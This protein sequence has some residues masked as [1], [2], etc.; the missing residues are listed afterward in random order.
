MARDDRDPGLADSKRKVAALTAP[1]NVV[2]VGASD[3]PGSWAA[4]VFEN[5]VRY[6]FP[7]PVYLVNPRRSE[8][9]GRPCYPDFRALPEPPD[10]LCVVVPAPFVS[11]ALK[12]AAAAG[13]RSATVLSAGFGE[14]GDLAGRALRRELEATIAA[15]GLAVSGPNC[16]GNI[17]G[18]SRLVTISD[19][20][21]IELRPGPVALVGQSGG[22][23]IFTN[24]VL[25]ERG[26]GTGYLITSG[27]E[28]GLA[29][30]DYIAFFADEPAIR[31]VIC[32]IE[33]V[34]HLQR[35]KAACAAMSTA[36]KTVIA[37]KLGR[38]EAGKAAAMAHTGSLAGST[39][40]FDAVAGELGV[41]RVDTL[42]EAVE[43]AEL[44]LH[45]GAPKGRRLGAV[46]LSGAYRGLLI[47]AAERNGLAFPAL[48][49]AT[50]ATLKAH[51]SVGSLVANPLDGGFGVLGSLET[52]LACVEALDHDPNIDALL[53]QDELPRGPGAERPEAYIR[54]IEHYAATKA[55]KPI[56]FVSLL[57]H[58]Q[59]AFSRALRAELPHLSFLNE[60]EKTLRVMDRIRA[61]AERM[62]LKT[63]PP[64]AASNNAA[65]ESLR[66]LAREATQPVA[67]DEVASKALIRAYGIATPEE[68][69]ARSPAEAVAAAHRIGYPVVLKIVS[70][71]IAHKSDV[72][73]VL[74]GLG[75]DDAVRAGYATILA[76][77]ARH[78]ASAA[79]EGML[80]ARHIAGGVELALGL[81]RDPEMGLV[82]MAAS[83]GVL[84]E[85][86]KDAAF[87][88]PPIGPAKARDMLRRLRAFRLLEG[89]RGSAP[90]D[91]DAVAATLAALGRIALE[92]GDVVQSLDI[93]PFL[94]LPAGSAALD[95]LVVIGK[96]AEAAN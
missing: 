52:Y 81:H 78:R 44:L 82:V 55:R 86:V 10:H 38:S 57:S 62:E 59:S 43:A 56:A 75:D 34:A 22:V 13:A 25:E 31:V 71:G 12:E 90:C 48:A 4:R 21:P 39:E 14:A 41:I 84:L 7:G 3:R 24:T 17:C 35:F 73:G 1:L 23:M 63:E 15:T 9:W 93:N 29:L 87:A 46:T 60:A 18:Q 32:Y 40:V 42:D 27:N 96:R 54:G 2:L 28:A 20:R 69:L 58:S 64:A 76:N 49:P 5:L 67:L 36:G 50:E 30:A 6:E 68:A 47:E 83:G 37:L 77:L 72:G 88:A 33:A 26:I 11:A 92:L 80:V 66:A 94:A 61:S 74:V 45:T 8:L 70:S 91:L 51:L 85:L 19:P 89:Y 53:L 79:V 95:A 16:M 65:A